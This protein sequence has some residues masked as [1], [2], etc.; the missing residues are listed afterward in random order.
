MEEFLRLTKEITYQDLEA[1]H[2]RYFNERK[3][4]RKNY[5]DFN[6]MKKE[7]TPIFEK[8][9]K[10]EEDANKVVHLI[11]IFPNQIKNTKDNLEIMIL[12]SYFNDVR[13]K[14]FV[15]L[16]QSVKYNMNLILEDPE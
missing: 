11:P 7:A 5:D 3:F 13:K 15:E 2:H 9:E 4:D 16:Y 14:R 1:I 10:W 8:I 12:H 6:L